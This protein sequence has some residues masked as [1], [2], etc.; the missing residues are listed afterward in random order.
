VP[1]DAGRLGQG[2]A[3]VHA[4]PFALG[5]AQPRPGDLAV[6]RV[7]LDAAVGQDVPAG[8]P[9]GEVEDR[10]PVLQSRREW[11]VTAGWRAVPRR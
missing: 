7:G 3:H 2:V 8:D 9:D 11:L 4:H 5:E 6:D 10:R 1:V